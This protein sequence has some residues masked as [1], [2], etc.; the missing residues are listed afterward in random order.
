MFAKVFDSFDPSR[1][2]NWGP[3]GYGEQGNLPFLLMGKWEYAYT[4]EGNLGTKW[5]LGNNLEFLL[6]EQSKHFWGTR[7]ILEIFL[8]NTGIQ[9]PM[10]A[11]VALLCIFHDKGA[12]Y[13][14][15]FESTEVQLFL[16]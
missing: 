16:T 4:F 5:I 7:E 9:T 8:S 12:R 15:S 1:V 3:R 6:R 14:L 11:C 10:G 2:Y 13:I